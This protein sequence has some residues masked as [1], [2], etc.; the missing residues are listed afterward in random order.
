MSELLATYKGFLIFKTKDCFEIKH[1]DLN[2]S[3]GEFRPQCETQED[4]MELIDEM[5]ILQYVQE[6]A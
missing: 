3:T 4:A 2:N 1:P 6:E 5:D